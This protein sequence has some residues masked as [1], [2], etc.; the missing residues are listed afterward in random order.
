MLL[1]IVICQNYLLL[2]AAPIGT[3]GNDLSGR[4]TNA[5]HRLKLFR[6]QNKVRAGGSVLAW[7]RI[8]QL[9]E[10]NQASK[11]QFQFVWT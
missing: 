1:I 10:S 2:N 11:L 3:P 6:E 7:F 5:I 9:D 4:L 8:L